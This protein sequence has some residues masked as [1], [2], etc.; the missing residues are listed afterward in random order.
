MTY[1]PQA[2]DGRVRRST[3]TTVSCATS[4]AP[5]AS[6]ADLDRS[7]QVP[8]RTGIRAR[9][10]SS[11]VQPGGQRSWQGTIKFVAVH[12]AALT[13]QQVQQNYA[14]GVGATYYL[15]FDVSC[16]DRHRHSRT[17]C[18]RRASTIT[19]AIC[20]I[21]PTFISLDSCLDAVSADPRFRAS[22]LAM[23]GQELPVDQ[24]YIP[25]NVT[26]ERTELLTRPRD[27]CSRP[28]ARSYRCRTV[29]PRISSS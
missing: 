21:S 10:S 4:T 12:N 11:A 5:C 19:T 13:Q 26:D 14:A 22:V 1:D 6:S 24:A 15:L 3:W 2:A 20:S 23:N 28:S 27:S 17:S 9:C 25:L 7:R 29:R 18:S 16:A 8:S